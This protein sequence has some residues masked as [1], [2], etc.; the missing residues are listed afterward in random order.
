[1]TDP[2]SRYMKAC[3]QSVVLGL[4]LATSASVAFS[5]TAFGE[6]NRGPAA[7]L[8]EL[9]DIRSHVNSLYSGLKNIRHDLEAT[10]HD[11]DHGRNFL[12]RV[13]EIELELQRYVE[14]S[15]QFEA[16]IYRDLMSIRSRVNELE[17]RIEKEIG[18]T[19]AGVASVPRWWQDPQPVFRSAATELS[20]Y[21]VIDDK[22]LAELRHSISLFD[23]GQ[24]K[25]AAA[26]FGHY[27]D[28]YPQSV[29]SVAAYLYL[30][31]AHANLGDWQRASEAYFTSFSWGELKATAPTAL[32]RLGQVSVQ[33]DAS[34]DICFIFDAVVLRYPQSLESGLASEEMQ[35]LGCDE[36]N[37]G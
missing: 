30:G 23:K 9:A 35:Q 3:W 15:E 26:G 29:Y 18:E 32:L 22:D 8:A 25:A 20:R 6:S 28:L 5:Q 7:L 31:E 19:D 11:S 4:I 12:R 33:K 36:S 10:D 2:G 13:H 17:S 37:P 21:G 16:S 14:R 27:V 24:F 34:R 1:M